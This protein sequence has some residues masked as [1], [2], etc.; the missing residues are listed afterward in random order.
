LYGVTGFG[1]ANQLGVGFSAGDANALIKQYNERF[2]KIKAFTDGLI[3]EARFKGFTT[4]MIGRRRYFAD[5][6][7]ANQ[8]IRKYAE[9]QAMNAPI[10]GTAADMIKLAMLKLRPLL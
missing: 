4:T 1:L 8:G 5:I 6:N 7:A 2:P 3:E 10:Q 9:R